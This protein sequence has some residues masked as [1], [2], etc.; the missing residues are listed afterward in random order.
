VETWSE[1]RIL[2]GKFFGLCPLRIPKRIWEDDINMDLRVV[3]CEHQRWTE[4]VQ[5]RGL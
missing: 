5:D 3:G 1:Y 2:R 4:V